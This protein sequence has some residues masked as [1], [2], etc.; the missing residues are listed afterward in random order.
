M[1]ITEAIGDYRTL[2]ECSILKPLHYNQK[3]YKFVW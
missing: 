1:I 3:I 2:S